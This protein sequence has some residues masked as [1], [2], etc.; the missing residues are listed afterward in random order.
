MRSIAIAVAL[1]LTSGCSDPEPANDVEG[2]A[3]ES[4]STGDDVGETNDDGSSSGELVEEWP[5][6]VLA[7]VRVITTAG[8]PCRDACGASVCMGRLDPEEGLS[9]CTE[10]RDEAECMCADFTEEIA[11][12]T[13]HAFSPCWLNPNS[14]STQAVDPPKWDQGTCDDFC[15]RFGYTCAGTI[16]SPAKECPNVRE[17]WP[18][19]YEDGPVTRPAGVEGPDGVFVAVCQL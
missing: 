11:E 7:D 14:G 15:G 1:L 16:W 2:T 9:P 19:F 8:E 10:Y 18:S 3:G 17:E 6:N 5:G 12:R 4:S 13:T